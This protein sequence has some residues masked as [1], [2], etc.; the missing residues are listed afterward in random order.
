M[1]HFQGR[2]EVRLSKKERCDFCNK[3]AS[4]DGK[5]IFGYWAYM[6][7]LC[8]VMNGIGLGTGVGQKLIYVRER[9]LRQ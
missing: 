4:F 5:T 6:C 9:S 8:F 7:K 1:K 3:I 2:K